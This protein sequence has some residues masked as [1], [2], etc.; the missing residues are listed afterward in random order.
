MRL[1]P[2]VGQKH[3]S[4]LQTKAVSSVDELNAFLSKQWG[5]GRNLVVGWSLMR[6]GLRLL[7]APRSRIFQVA[8]EDPRI[9]RGERLMSQDE[10]MR[11]ARQLNVETISL[12][13][14]KQFGEGPGRIS[15][16]AVEVLM[17][18]YSILETEHRGVLLFDIT[19]FGR[20]PPLG[21]VA[22]LSYLDH[23]INVAQRVVSDAQI[24]V[25]V[26]RSTTGDGFYCWNRREGF[27]SDANLF[28]FKAVTLAL[29]NYM[30]QRET[31]SYIPTTKTCASI[32]SHYTYFSVERLNPRGS[33]YIV[34][35]VT[36]E[37]AR[38]MEAADPNQI[39]IGNFV[40]PTP[41]GEIFT[42]KD[43][44]GIVN[45]KM[46]A[47]CGR[48]L[49][50]AKLRE[51]KFYLTGKQ[52]DRTYMVDRFTIEDKHGYKHVAFNA[53]INFHFDDGTSVYLG[54]PTA[55]ARQDRA[56]DE[57]PMSEI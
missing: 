21:Q 55:E 4:M 45:E 31:K 1:Q 28:A 43:F 22:Q 11:R 47:F 25:E 56:F 42:P 37:L 18:R 5:Y 36:I 57:V 54:L 2:V 32:G 19:G 38:L 48:R 40:R 29:L 27:D 20:L 51:V 3:M 23:A 6:V 35:D 34:G 17:R 8:A 39:L 12:S 52:V 44:A 26:N 46:R 50:G 24:Y 33:N 9:V 53:K 49:F 16:S 14:T 30:R 7:M 15:F 41:A 13:V 10:L